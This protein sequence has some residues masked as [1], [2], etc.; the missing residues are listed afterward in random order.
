MICRHDYYVATHG[1]TTSKKLSDDHK[2]RKSF[3]TVICWVSSLG[4]L[5]E[6]DRGKEGTQD[7]ER[8]R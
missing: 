3:I 5:G 4:M 1:V 7:G 2:F 8:G 6:G